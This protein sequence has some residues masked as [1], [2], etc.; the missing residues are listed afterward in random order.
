MKK[1]LQS[2]KILLLFLSIIYIQSSYSQTTYTVTSTS[3][4]PKETSGTFLWAVEQANT[5]PGADIIEFTTGLQVDAQVLD[6]APGSIMARITDPVTIDGKGGALNGLQQWFGQGGIINSTSDCPGSVSGTFQLAFMPGFLEIG[7]NG[8]DNSAINVSIKNLT[9]KQF[10]QV[11]RIHKNASLILDNFTANETWASLNCVSE[12]M[13]QGFEGSSLT[14]KNSLFN[15][16]YNWGVAPFAASISMTTNAG[17]LNIENS[18]FFGLNERTQPA[19]IHFGATGSKVNI[20]SSRF[21]SS[22]GITTGGGVET[23]IVN[24]ILVNKDSEFLR[25]G[26]LIINGSSGAMNIIASSIMWNGFECD[27][28]CQQALYT[29]LI[30]INGSGNI[31]LSQS[32]IGFNYP[33]STNA[34]DFINTLGIGGGTGVF[35]ADTYTYIQPSDAQD[36]AALKTITSQPAL[37]TGTAFNS[38]VTPLGTED[39]EVEMVTPA[40]AGELIDVIPTGNPLLNP[41]DGSTITLD[42]VGNPREDANGKRDI[43]ALQ[44]ALAPIISVKSIADAQVTIR[45]NEPLHHNGLTI[46]RYELVHDVPGG[47][48][49]TTASTTSDLHT[50]AGLTNGT[51]Y[52]FKVRAVYDNGGTEENGPYS[53]TV[54]A[55]PYGPVANPALNAYP[56]NGEVKLTW[57]LPDLG[58]RPFSFYALRYRLSGDANVI[59]NMPI[60]NS[61]TLE[62]TFTG[63]TNGTAYDF[64]IV[65]GALDGTYS[66]EVF[67][68]ATPF[69]I[70]NAPTVTA[71]P[72]NTEVALTWDL[73]DL[74]GGVFSFYAV[75][76]YLSGDINIVGNLPPIFN[77]NTLSTTI[78]GLTNGQAYDFIVQVV[79]NGGES[80][81]GVATATPDANLGIN[82]FDLLDGKFSYYPNPVN[83]YLHIDIEENF[84]AKLFSINGALLIDVKSKKIIDVSKFNT[85]IYILQVQIEDKIYSGKILKK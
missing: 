1:L 2:R 40:V 11:A 30:Q 85:G 65:V 8:Q 13:I 55:T 66:D 15:N 25:T 69:T 76:W 21:Y 20:V 50:V 52:E 18:R 12:E 37:L 70:T 44:L 35:T 41:I 17:D 77:S 43:G 48:N 14:I 84:T 80:P 82:D 79:A 19:I 31:N 47:S 58:G 33:A 73:P 83:D 49:P 32:A 45:W 3:V 22:G 59:G 56:A 36:A 28:L 64:S 61:N 75:K 67:K 42:V 78:T 62:Y 9:I 5:N 54:N 24:S 7:T 10:N 29:D 23:N 16:A 60:Y 6:V 71:T 39:F 72:G 51:A 74:G 4:G 46:V 68:T 34:T 38:P 57:N 63:L 26:D 81:E 53:N 27:A